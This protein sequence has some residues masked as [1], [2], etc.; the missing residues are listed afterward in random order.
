MNEATKRNQLSA[1]DAIVGRRSI[2]RFLSTPIPD[3]TINTILEIASRAPSNMNIQPWLVRVVTG[4]S[5]ARL[6]AAIR[7]AA[8]AGETG[9]EFRYSP[10]VMTE[11]YLSRKR[12]VGFSL[13]ALYDIQ[14]HDVEARKEAMLRNFDFF[15]A[16]VG[17]FFTMERRM[18]FGSWLDCGMLMQ[19]VM[20]I[21]RSFGLDTCPQQA[22]CDYAG[23][24]RRELVI[25]DDHI[26]LSGMSLGYADPTA[27]ENTLVSERENPANFAT[28]HR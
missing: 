4:D 12:K 22:W 5:G 19:N 27:P 26:V 7:R 23:V 15:G 2:R 21:A 16:P 20:I 28:W 8:E 3:E 17:L 6:S 1:Y 24:V 25:P 11:P 18:G 13:Y 10:E 14:R 9:S